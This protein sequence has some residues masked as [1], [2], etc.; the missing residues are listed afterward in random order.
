MF[1]VFFEIHTFPNSLNELRGALATSKLE[2]TCEAHIDDVRGNLFTAPI[3]TVYAKAMRKY[4]ARC[5]ELCEVT[6]QPGVYEGV[7][8]DAAWKRE[9]DRFLA[10]DHS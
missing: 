4:K 5:I 8:A 9:E 6:G 2:A 7:L 10:M 1:A 3:G